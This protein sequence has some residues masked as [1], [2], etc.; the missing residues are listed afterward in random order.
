MTRP[1]TS[2][3]RLIAAA[4]LC[5]SLTAPAL[6]NDFYQRPPVPSTRD[7]AKTTTTT[8]QK[9]ASTSLNN[10]KLTNKIVK[11]TKTGN[12]GGEGSRPK[13]SLQ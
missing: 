5:L 13:G 6:A 3:V 9:K 11:S 12:A 4:F 1:R 8:R 10:A 7:Q 2:P